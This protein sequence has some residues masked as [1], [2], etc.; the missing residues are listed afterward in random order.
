M[1]IRG[2]CSE[3]CYDC[4]PVIEQL[5]CASLHT[6]TLLSHHHFVSL[7]HTAIVD[8]NGFVSFYVQQNTDLIRLTKTSSEV[9]SC[10]IY[11][12]GKLRRR[13]DLNPFC[14]GLGS[15]ALLIKYP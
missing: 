15:L 3:L 11:N 5:R 14:P 4:F 9:R 6:V 13:T 7:L 12:V 2:T 10:K 8:I 1:W